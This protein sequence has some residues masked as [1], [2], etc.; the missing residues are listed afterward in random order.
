MSGIAPF[1]DDTGISDDEEL[2]RRIR[3]DIVH[4]SLADNGVPPVPRQGFQDYPAEKAQREFNLPG[5]CMSVDRNLVLVERGHSVETLVEGYESYGV[6][7]IEAGAVRSLKGP[8]GE[9]YSQGVMANPRPSAPWHA[10]V[11]CRAGGKKSK[12]MEN[13]LARI[14]RWV[15]LPARP[16]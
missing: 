10:V 13:A 7:S 3:P 5:A 1:F 14:A 12:G 16:A 11:F 15:I 4:W 6:V 8:K 2:Y 9:D